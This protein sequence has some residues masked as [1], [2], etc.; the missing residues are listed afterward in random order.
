MILLGD[1]PYYA[2]FGFTAAKTGELQLPGPFERER[3][4][5]L[6]LREGALDGAWGMIVPTGAPRH[7]QGFAREA[8]LRPRCRLSGA[9]WQSLPA[10]DD[11]ARPRW[12]GAITTVLMVLIAVMIVRDIFARRWSTAAPAAPTSPARSLKKRV[13]RGREMPVNRAR[14]AKSR[15]RCHAA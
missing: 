1:A 14:N 4:L 6:E 10:R 2:R 8:A 11:G 9:A 12:R 13:A 7:A 3:L 5:G 15:S